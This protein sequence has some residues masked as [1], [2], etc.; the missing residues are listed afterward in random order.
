M[1]NQ[2]NPE[3][4]THGQLVA[5]Y[6]GWMIYAS[7]HPHTYTGV[8]EGKIVTGDSINDVVQQITSRVG[9]LNRKDDAWSG[10]VCETH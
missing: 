5:E 8:N 2:S 4:T 6:G 10:G 7:A 1:F 9:E 3:I